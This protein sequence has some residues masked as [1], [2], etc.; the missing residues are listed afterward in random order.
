MQKGFTLIEL[1]VV[2]LIMGILASVAWPQYQ[3]AVDK[4]RLAGAMTLAQSLRKAQE[5]YYMANGAYSVDLDNFDID[6]SKSCQRPSEGLI[7]CHHYMIDNIYGLLGY[8]DDVN[9]VAIYVPSNPG[10]TTPKDALIHVYF[11]HSSRPHEITCEGL[12]ERG[13]KICRALGYTVI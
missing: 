3:L 13:K 9:Q 11:E 5:V 8:S 6:L 2:V 4:S 1:L 10:Q 12:T 7:N